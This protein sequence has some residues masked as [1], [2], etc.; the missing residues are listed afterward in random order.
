MT[1][2]QCRAKYRSMLKD[3]TAYLKK[4]GDRLMASGGIDIG[5]ASDDYAVPKTILYVA[6]QNLAAQYSPFSDEMHKAAKNLRH[7]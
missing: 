1:S 4:G 5:G 3:C 6:A 7:F 2:A